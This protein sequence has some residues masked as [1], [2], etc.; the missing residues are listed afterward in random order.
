[1]KNWT[2]PWGPRQF[3][4]HRITKGG[5]CSV[6][7]VNGLIRWFLPKGTNFHELEPGEIN[8]IE[9][10][11][12]NRPR[13][14]LN[15]RTP[16]EVFR[17]ARDALDVWMWGLMV[18]LKD[19]DLSDFWDERVIR[20]RRTIS[21]TIFLVL[22]GS[23]CVTQPRFLAQYLFFSTRSSDVGLTRC[24]QILTGMIYNSSCDG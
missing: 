4:V 17:E 21:L 14:C 2:R 15:D 10:L 3:F 13:K 22:M 20:M 18:S 24:N 23:L 11:L 9:K 8:R 5:K 7:Q 6:E 16:Y 19:V 12:N 1:M